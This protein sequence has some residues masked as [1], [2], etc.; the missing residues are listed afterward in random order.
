M[1]IE[2]K[3]VLWYLGVGLVFFLMMRRG[4]CCGGHHHRKQKHNSKA[5]TKGEQ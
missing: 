3:N 1:N 4:G 5:V 2:L